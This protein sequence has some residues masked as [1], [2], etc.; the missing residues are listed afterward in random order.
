VTNR[1][2]QKVKEVSTQPLKQTVQNELVAP[3][4]RGLTL[5]N[6]FKTGFSNPFNRIEILS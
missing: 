3:V 1:I 2:V 5:Q 4:F 6:L